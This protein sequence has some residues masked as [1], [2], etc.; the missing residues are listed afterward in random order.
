MISELTN[1]KMLAELVVNNPDLERLET[2]LDQFNIFEAIGAVR[3]ELRHSDFLAF[4]LD[5]QRGHGLGDVFL[6]RLLQRVLVSFDDAALPVT[7]IDFDIWNLRQATVQREWQNIDILLT[8]EVN[9]I[10]VIIE[11]KIDSSEHSQQLARY[12]R[13]VIS[14]YPG[15]KVIGL[16]LT[17]EGDMP[18]DERYLPV[19]YKLISDIIQDL[20][21]TRKST[22]GADVQTLMLHYT[23]MLRR[24]IVSE[25]EI[26]EL[27]RRIYQKH[28]SALDLI[29]EH[30]PDKQAVTRAL[31]EELV[32]SSPGIIADRLGKTATA[33]SIQEW[34]VP[35]L[36]KSSGWTTSGRV[37]LF[38]F[39]NSSD[40]LKLH[41]VIGPG[42]QTVR[43]KLLDMSLQA[44]HPFNKGRSLASK[45]NRIYSLEFLSAKDYEEDLV[46]ERE[47]KIR[48]QWKKFLNDDLPKIKSAIN[49]SQL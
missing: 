24:H 20:A 1:H 47:E 43:Q 32:K 23:Q 34:E 14:R 48:Q 12:W 5:P 49:L 10:V 25:S 44:G 6:K 19:G 45:F 38:E 2:L 3:Q 11:N 33:F 37:L 40:A 18:S 16:F 46:E 31:L 15:W 29:Y 26:A 28:K 17:R 36:S 27:C 39:F 8:D 7:P 30:R 21:E 22:L 9:K 41:L 13:S 35:S 4:L 42:P